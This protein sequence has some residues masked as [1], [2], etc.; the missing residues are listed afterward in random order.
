[1]RF[2]TI[3]PRASLEPV[4][5]VSAP[6]GTWVELSALTSK[7]VLQLEHALP[8]ILGHASYL[9]ERV[10]RWGGPRYRESEFSFLPPV[11]RP[12]SFRDFDAF[13][14]HFKNARERLGL[15]MPSEWYAEPAFYFA[16]RLTLVGHDSPV[17]APADS[18]EL[19]FGLALGIVIGRRGRDISV[20]GAWSH[21]AGF[22]IVNDLSARDLE[23]RSLP[24]GLGPAKAK[25]FAT[26]VGPWLAFVGDFSDKIEGERL[27]LAMKA[28]VNGR[29]IVTADTGSLYHTIPRL[30]A[31]ASRD[32]ELVPGDL[33]S[34]G[35]ANGGSLWELENRGAWLQPGDRVSLEVERIG[36]LET[37]VA[38]RPEVCSYAW[39]SAGTDKAPSPF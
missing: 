27:S 32:A 37:P 15:S 19:D 2:A 28:S 24:A 6:D 20:A 14:L 30:V 5:V 26:A 23:R 9:V 22:T 1:M 38:A 17:C 16:N 35:A 4:T 25:D 8:W 36:V 34:T 7:K 39:S 11:V 33:L 3:L 13:E 21:V 31:Y 18:R 12:A 10:E 29:T